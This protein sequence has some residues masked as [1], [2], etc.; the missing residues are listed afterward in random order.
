M[1]LGKANLTATP[2]ATL[3]NDEGPM[4]VISTGRP[5]TAPALRLLAAVA[6]L[7]LAGGALAGCSSTS[8]EAAANSGYTTSPSDSFPVTIEHKFGETVV[9]AEPQRIV[10]VGLTEQDVLLEL[11]VVPVATTEWY[12][13]QPYAV[14]P[15][16]AELLGDAEPTVL[17]QTD[18]LEYEKIAALKPDLILGTNAGL[19]EEDYDKLADIAPTVTSIEGSE[20]YFSDWQDQTRQIAAAVGRSAEGDALIDGVEKAYADAAAAHPEFA[21]LTASFSQGTPYEGTLWVYPDGVNTDFLT[22]LGFVITPGLAEYAANEGE[23]AQISPENIGLIDADVIVFA[24]ETPEGVD[25]VLGF[26]TASSLGAVT[27]NHAVFTDAELAGAIY[28]L[29]PLSQKY[30]LEKLV[31]RLTDAVN[32]QAP[33]NT[34]G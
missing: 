29:T 31:P 6:T 8:S 24:T 13:A 10:V 25:E 11:G 22:D 33:R 5:R 20:R 26:G 3:D 32:G 15:W 23:Q 16:A 18:G 14:W 30:V 2:H 1:R 34:E 7:A 19:T 4:N 27:G 12:G 17:D 28:F 9:A 21:G